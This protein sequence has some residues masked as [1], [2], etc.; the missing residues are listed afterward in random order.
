M[1]ERPNL[2]PDSVQ[3]RRWAEIDQLFAAL[4]DLEPA[5]REAFLAESCINDEEL[6]R[7]VLELLELSESS[8]NGLGH[9]GASL[10]LAAWARTIS[11]D[12]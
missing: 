11:R 8:L 6:R 1:G 3:W 10:L 4:L 2:D 7:T 5:G 9:P 12:R